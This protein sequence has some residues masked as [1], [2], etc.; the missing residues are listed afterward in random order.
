MSERERPM[1]QRMEGR[2]EK[3]RE[4]IEKVR[5]PGPGRECQIPGVRGRDTG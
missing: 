5:E 2:R 1:K 4:E 3:R